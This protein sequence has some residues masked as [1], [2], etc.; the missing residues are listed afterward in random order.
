MKKLCSVETLKRLWSCERGAIAP[1]VG[2]CAIMLVGAVAVAVDVGRGQVAQSKLQAALDAAGLAAG[3]VVAQNLDAEDLKPEAWKYL[4]ENFAGQTVDAVITPD[5]FDLELSDDQMLVTLEARASLPTTFMR[6]FGHD[7]MHVAART[8]ITRE[9][10]G[11]EVALV[12]DVTGSMTG[13]VS[14][15]DSTEKIAALRSAADDLMD[16]LFGDN[17]TVDDLWVGIVPFSQTVNIGTSRTDWLTDYTTKMAYDNCVGWNHSNWPHTHSSGEVT[18]GRYCPT[19]GPNVSTRTR[20]VTLVNDWLDAPDPVS[21]KVVVPHLNW[22]G[23]MSPWYF[24]PSGWGGCIRERYNTGRDVTDAPLATEKFPTFFAP[25]NSDNEWVRL[26]G[27]NVGNYRIL[28]DA[29]NDRGPNHGCPLQPITVMT[30]DKSDLKAAVSQLIN[31]RGNTH[32]NVGAVWG[33]RLLSP[34][35]RNAWGTTMDANNLPLDYDEPLSQKV[36]ILMTDGDNTMPDNFATAYGFLSED[37]LVNNDDV[38]DAADVLDA[39]LLTVCNA[40]KAKGIIIYTIGLGDELDAT[41]PLLKSCASTSDY[42]FD[43]R[44]SADLDSAFHTIGDALSKL[45]VSK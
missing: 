38:D 27:N 44:T 42:F 17:D 28:V 2:I 26:S 29:N 32:T 22:N 11:L 20:Q 36:M 3:A 25:Y 16:I 12:L 15:T 41:L 40:M 24:R 9:M 23:P 4:K 33:W 1:I 8:E 35:W 18:T 7:T 45:R 30:N 13:D 21:P 10:T 34:D 6:I 19:N 37:H 5:D 43:A 39:K 14:D 31:P